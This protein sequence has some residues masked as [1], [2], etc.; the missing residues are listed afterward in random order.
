MRIFTHHR[1]HLLTALHDFIMAVLSFLLASYLRLGNDL[2]DYTGKFLLFDTLVCGC[3]SIGIFTL[4]RLYRGLWRYSSIPD[5]I[6]IIKAVTLALL[7]SYTII[8][9]TN[10]LQGVPRSLPFIQWLLLLAMLGSPRFIYRIW[11][12][13]RLGIHAN[14]HIARKIPVILI[15]AGESAELFLRDTFSG[16]SQHYHVVAI[17]DEKSSRTGSTIHNVRIYGTLE[18]L[19]AI[20]T[21]LAQK[22][23]KPQ[24]LIITHDHLEGAKIRELLAL[25]NRLGLPLSRLPRLNEFKSGVQ[26]KLE[27]KPIAVE[28]LLGRSQ[29]IHDKSALSPYISNKIV[30]ITGAGGSIGSELTRQLAA[31]KPKQLLLYEL[32]EFLLYQIDRELGEHFPTLPRLAIIGDVRDKGHL[33]QVFA[34]HKPQ[35]V[36]HAAAIKHVP[37]AEENCEEAVLTNLFG[38]KNLADTALLHNVESMVMI[39]TDKA[40]N[41]SSLMGATKRAAESYCQA[42]SSQPSSLTPSSTR[43]ITVR[44]GNVLGSNGSVVPLFQQQLAAGGPITVTHPDMVRYFMTIREAVELILQSMTIANGK[45]EI[46]VLDMGQPVK[47]LDLAE[48]MIT[49]AGLKP[50]E[51]IPIIFTGLRKGEKMFEELFHFGE[52][53]AKTAQ[54]GIW[55][56]T[57]RYGG[58]EEINLHLEA[59]LTACQNRD[60]AKT[61]CLIQLLVPEYE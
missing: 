2:I 25:A 55:L 31:L 50:Y 15:G 19:P 58:L 18:E 41:P 30:L 16:L 20:I 4:M 45:G 29:N 36:F 27:I 56:A 22:G 1:R 34:Q 46:C 9:I 43:F 5:L 57:P 38:T 32:S 6:A 59:L 28:D 53:H 51:D 14:L 21:S 37:L 12:D 7:L 23:L 11:R 13:R 33:E 10:R 3:V 8:F 24:R 48:Q 42:L 49:L 54:T 61:R 47:I 52:E 60:A 44:F 17:V 39:S 35:V 26:E 40:V